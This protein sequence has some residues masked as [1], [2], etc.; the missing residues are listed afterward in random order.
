VIALVHHLV[1]PPV[2]GMEERVPRGPR[3]LAAALY[4]ASASRMS[5]MTLLLGGLMAGEELVSGVLVARRA[6][7]AAVARPLRRTAMV[8]R[9]LGR[10]LVDALSAATP[11]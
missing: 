8:M 2:L 4:A 10:E 1:P 11:C 9:S 5:A 3:E 7:L 6:G